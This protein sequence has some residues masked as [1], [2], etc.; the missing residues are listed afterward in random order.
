VWLTVYGRLRTFRLQC[1][2]SHFSVYITTVTEI[3]STTVMWTSFIQNA[4]FD[5]ENTESSIVSGYDIFHVL[6]N[7]FIREARLLCLSATYV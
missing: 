7:F 5:D 4:T 1:I 3:S 2:R 6:N